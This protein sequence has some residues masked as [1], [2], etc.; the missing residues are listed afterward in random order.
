MTTDAPAGI[1]ALL[2]RRGFDVTFEQE[3]DTRDPTQNWLGVEGA[4]Q[5]V[6]VKGAVIPVSQD[7]QRTTR[8]KLDVAVIFLGCDAP[9][10]LAS[11]VRVSSNAPLT[12]GAKFTVRVI[13]QFAA[14]DSQGAIEVGATK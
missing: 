9:S 12:A 5:S 2:K 4:E 7:L 8:I 11:G 3:N 10:W 6:T 13:R 1:V 14:A